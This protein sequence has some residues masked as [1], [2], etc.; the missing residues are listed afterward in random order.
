MIPKIKAKDIKQLREQYLREQGGICALCREHIDPEEAVL[1][2]CHK[3]GFIRSVLHRG[4]NSFIGHFENN[5]ARNRITQTK[6]V[7]ILA[8][9]LSYV[10]TY[11]PI[12]HPTHKTPEEKKERARKRAKAKRTK[13][14]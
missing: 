9:F 1:D 13:K 4:C 11:K 6:L 5:Q 12:L 7:N 2:H 3:T 14:F 10:Q 8:N